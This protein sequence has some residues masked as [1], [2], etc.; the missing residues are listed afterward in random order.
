MVDGPDVAGSL[1]IRMVE[2][3]LRNPVTSGGIFVSLVMVGVI[4]ANAFANQPKPHPHPFFTTRLADPARTAP[5]GGAAVPTAPVVPSVLPRPK[6]AAA[7]DQPQ[8]IQDLQLALR[9]RGFY[10]GPLD[11]VVGPATADAIRA[12]ERR[13]G[14]PQTGEPTDLLIAAVRATP[15]LPS[16]AA[17]PTPPPPPAA[18]TVPAR[19]VATGPTP[20]LRVP[21]ADAV[22]WP[23]AAEVAPLEVEAPV[24]TATIRRAAREPLARGGDERLQKI[25]RAL[26]GAGYGP[27]K[28]DGRWDDHATSAVRR[29]E[30]DRG[31]PVTGKPSDR[32]VYDL[33][34]GGAQARR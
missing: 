7:L 29:Y 1:P 8:A 3:V 27:L 14:A 9:D 12:F 23:A 10:T 18:P 32:L 20:P 22:A 2:T 17:A 5:T 21:A 19:A 24:A 15:P 13:L 16:V 4:V 28:A 30:A 26:I 6:P 34:L 31:W 11:G 25:Q 33:M